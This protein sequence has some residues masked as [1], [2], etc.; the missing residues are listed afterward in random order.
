VLRG[1]YPSISAEHRAALAARF[2]LPDPRT[3]LGPDL[4]GIAHAMIDISDGLIA[5]LGHICETSGVAATVEL[6]RL[7]L[8][9]AA[10]AIVAGDEALRAQ[11][12]TGGDDYELLFAAPAE[13]DDEIIS[14]SNGMGLPITEIGAIEAGAGV[15]LIDKQGAALP[16]DKT[17]WRHF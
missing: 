8:S 5:D 3:Q 14:L 9:P 12:A 10:K 2:R 16:I 13:A 4:A 7:P 1:D 15:R 11:L 17:G 6:G